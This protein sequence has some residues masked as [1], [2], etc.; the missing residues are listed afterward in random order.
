MTPA[1]EIV[2]LRLR[3]RQL[4]SNARIAAHQEKIQRQR[5]DRAE[6]E[7]REL[8]RV[9]VLADVELS[10]L[11]ILLA[12]LDSAHKGQQPDRSA[13]YAEAAEIVRKVSA[14]LFDAALREP[15]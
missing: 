10:D 12:A 13:E 15:R 6:G 11:L 3:V 1:D 9:G 4:E 14:M 2:A 8:R 5:A 7:A